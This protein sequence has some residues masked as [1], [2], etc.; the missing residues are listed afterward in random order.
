MY[1][2]Q[3]INIKHEWNLSVDRAE[4]RALRSMLGACG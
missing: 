4:K 1:A 2:K 3:W